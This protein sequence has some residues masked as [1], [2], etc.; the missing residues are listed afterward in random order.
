MF[1]IITVFIAIGLYVW[2]YKVSALFILFFF[3]TSG[4]NLIP[5]EMLESIFFS[6]GMDY[7]I[8]IIV[9][10]VIID[11]FCIKGYLNR[12][13][14]IW[15]ILI[16]YAFLG[17]CVIY[18]KYFIGTSLKEI[19]RTARYNLLWIAYLVFRHLSKEQLQRL[20]KFLFLVT[21]VCAALF[22][23]QII[24]DQHILIEGQKFYYKL[25]GSRIPRFYNQPDM[26]P[27]FVF[28]A[29]YFNPF[30]GI[31]KIVTVI[32]LVIALL[33]AF[34]RSILIAFIFAISIGYII[35][36]PRPKRI[37]VLI[38]ISII[39]FIF[40]VFFGYKFAN[41]RTIKDIAIVTSGNVAE[42]GDIETEIDIEELQK[43]TFTFR[44]AHLLERNRYVIDNKKAI[45]FGAGLM[46]EDSKKTASMFDFKVGLSDE[47]LGNAVQLDTGDISYSF[48]LMRY[49][50][51][52]TFIVLSLYIFFMIY[53]YKNLKEPIA[54]FSFICLVYIMII[55]FFS[56]ILT[57][58]ISFLLPLIS[59]SILQKKSVNE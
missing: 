41:S 14:L 50:Y 38:S 47:A 29:I 3:L 11:S 16:F 48:L 7:A 20:M 6:K 13:K 18:N 30:K 51:L 21:V 17:I 31:P 24:F 1:Y 37:P 2:G 54:F 19:I 39:G 22:I 44:I 33:G 45:L 40:V 26:L 55:S 23:L 59:Y 34:H 28:M 15:L 10:I 32:I 36:L 46:T 52:G 58:P 57:T 4:F 43:S 8:L 53:F 49:G 27:F 9:G 56:S 5:E 42:F 25:F 12:D 35:R